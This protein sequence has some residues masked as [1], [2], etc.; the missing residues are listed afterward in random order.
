VI[1]SLITAFLFIMGNTL[2]LLWFAVLP[3]S[4]F[5]KNK[6]PNEK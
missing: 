4:I 6:L 5:I 3:F 1:A 2:G